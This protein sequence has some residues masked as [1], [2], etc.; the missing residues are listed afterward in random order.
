MRAGEAQSRK[1]ADMNYYLVP[2][3]AALAPM[4][5]PMD[6]ADVAAVRARSAQ[7]SARL[8]EYQSGQPLTVT[9]VTIPGGRG[10]ADILGRI[11]APAGIASPVPALIYLH[12]GGF[13]VG[14]LESGDR[15][16][17]IIADQAGAVVLVLDYRLAPEHPYPASLDDCYAALNWITSAAAARHGID[18][19][20]V[21]VMGDSSGGTLAAA[22]TMLDR[23]R[24]GSRLVAQFLDSPVIDNRLCTHSMRNLPDTPLWQAR[25]SRFTW[26]Y[27]LGELAA[28]D[29]DLPI[30]AVP[31]RARPE[32]LAGLPPA[33]VTCYQVDPNRDEGLDYA[34]R[35]TEAGVPTEV[36]Q[37]S[38]AFH[39]AHEFPGTAIGVRMIANRN[40]A[41][42]RMLFGEQ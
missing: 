34:R 30:Y 27:Y 1:E 13:V 16:G 29:Q 42:R 4:I 36:H 10:T 12:G 21:A 23:D 38:G 7:M 39:M 8:P 22:L 40:G 37:Y 28:D 17:R 5:P 6:F 2:E 24:G 33:W 14:D 32:D 31:G 18:T 41:V 11:Y 9:D 25:N 20:R 3:L 35:L 15:T 26:G 19:G